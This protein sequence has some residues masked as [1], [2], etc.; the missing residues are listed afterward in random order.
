MFIKHNLR[1]SSSIFIYGSKNVE[2]RTLKMEKS[3]VIRRRHFGQGRQNWRCTHLSELW[4]GALH[5]L[6]NL[7][8]FKYKY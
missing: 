7:F 1:Y 6:V 5:V 2:N 3:T 8:I 4:V